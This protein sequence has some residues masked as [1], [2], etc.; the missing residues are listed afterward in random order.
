MNI[1]IR[2]DKN[3]TTQ[4]NK[5]QEKYGEEFARLNGLSDEQLSYTD[6]ISNFIESETV[7]D[8]SVDSNANVG[9]K[10]IVTLLNE[11]PKPHRKLLAL[12]KIYYEMNKT[13]G[14]KVANDWLEKER[15]RA[16][17]NDIIHTHR[18]AIDAHC[19]MFIQQK[20]QFQFCTDSIRS[21]N[22]NRLGYSHQVWRK[23][24]PKSA[25]S[26]D[27][28]WCDRPGH[29]LFHEFHSLVSCC[30]INA[31]RFITLAFAF[32]LISS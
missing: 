13:Y 32:H 18:H 16:A 1:N 2:L 22:Q 4:F 25:D 14:F 23:Q 30:N 5:L 12:R 10:D 3:F 31:C 9:H 6:F 21:G 7:A 29:M 27:Y 8:A 26:V 28:P 17:A 19:I 24:S 20:R 15:S 11:M